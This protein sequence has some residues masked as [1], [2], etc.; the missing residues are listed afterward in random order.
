MFNGP[1]GCSF[2]TPPFLQWSQVALQ[3]LQVAAVLNNLAFIQ[4]YNSVQMGESGK[5]MGH[6]QYCFIRHDVV[7]AALDQAFGL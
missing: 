5:P 3:Q 1:E 4:H 7:Q 2:A 6:D